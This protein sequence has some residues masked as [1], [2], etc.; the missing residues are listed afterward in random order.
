MSHRIQHSYAVNYFLEKFFLDENADHNFFELLAE[1]FWRDIYGATF[2]VRR[3]LHRDLV[4]VIFAQAEVANLVNF[5]RELIFRCAL[6]TATLKKLR[7]IGESK[8]AQW[9]L[10]RMLQRLFFGG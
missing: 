8:E 3:L 10:C 9:T 5:F 6:V 1:I 2:L 7:C 4:A